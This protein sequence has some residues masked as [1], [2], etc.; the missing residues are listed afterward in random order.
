MLDHNTL[1]P[2]SNDI[3]LATNPAPIHG[4]LHQVTPQVIQEI[5]RSC[6]VD[7]AKFEYYKCTANQIIKLLRLK[8]TTVSL[9][10][11]PVVKFPYGLKP[12]YLVLPFRNC[13]TPC[14]QP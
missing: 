10:L 13:T 4:Q 1:C 9:H 11:Y 5:L 14:H 3:N 2:T 7:V 8:V 12:A 6:D